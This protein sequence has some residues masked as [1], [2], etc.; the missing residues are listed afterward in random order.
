M[1]SKLR[2]WDEHC[3]I[4]R[5]LRAIETTLS[6]YTTR[7]C[8]TCSWVNTPARPAATTAPLNDD[9][10]QIKEQMRQKELEVEELRKELR[11]IKRQLGGRQIDSARRLQG[12]PC[13]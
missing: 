11:E 7:C 5:V 6:P 1:V 2:A 4:V 10:Q 13:P 9:L 3:F 8:L 12:S